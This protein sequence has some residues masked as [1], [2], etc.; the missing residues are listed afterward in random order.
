MVVQNNYTALVFLAVIIL[1]GAIM[2]GFLLTDTEVFN[3]AKAH[4]EAN[5]YA[6]KSALDARE[7]AGI[8]QATET[9][10][11]LQVSALQTQT[12]S[13]INAAQTRQAAMAQAT[14]I[15][16]QQ[17]ATQAAVQV[18]VGIAQGNATQTAL[19]AEG[20]IRVEQQQATQAALAFCKTLTAQQAMA[21]A[22]HIAVGPVREEQDRAAAQTNQRIVTISIGAG[23]FILAASAGLFIVMQGRAVMSA[24]KAKTI[25]EQ[26]RMLQVQQAIRDRVEH[27]RPPALSLPLARHDGNR[28]SDQQRVA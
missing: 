26:R 9:P 17:T 8:L 24:A 3:P 19:A 22:T 15:P 5:T 13:V 2:L 11:A 6:T 12:A 16:V 28:Q 27:P 23:F 7:R 21:T 4:A 10:R 18:A 20:R 14:A 1:A 25:A